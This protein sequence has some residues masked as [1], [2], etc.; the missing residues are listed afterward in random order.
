[1][2]ATRGQCCAEHK[3][4]G[5]SVALLYIDVRVNFTLVPI[6]KGCCQLDTIN[7]LSYEVL[8]LVFVVVDYHL[9]ASLF[10]R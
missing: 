3:A 5:T 4:V 7:T 2:I 9:D 6:F 1:M 8:N 10:S